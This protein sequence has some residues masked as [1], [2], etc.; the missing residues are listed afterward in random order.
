MSPSPSDRND[1]LLRLVYV[2]SATRLLSDAELTDLLRTTRRNNPVHDITG[3]LLYRSGNFL[4]VLE[5]PPDSV[6]ATFAR[7]RRDPRH[8]NLIV[9]SREPHA[10]RA[11]PRWAMGFRHLKAISPDEDAQLQLLLDDPQHHASAARAW[12]L[13][14]TFTNSVR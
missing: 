5:G 6:E 8:H 3:M 2:S 10:R 11:F 7:I 1:D 12:R 14:E 9:L 13:I 4:Q